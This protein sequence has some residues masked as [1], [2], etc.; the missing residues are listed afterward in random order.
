MGMP[1]DTSAF[2]DVADDKPRGKMGTG[3][4]QISVVSAGGPV[5]IK[6]Q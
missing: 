6:K 1:V 3:A 5:T 2:P 4:A